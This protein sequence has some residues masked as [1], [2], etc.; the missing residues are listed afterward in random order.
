MP[1]SHAPKM[2]ANS[3]TSRRLAATAARQLDGPPP[4]S[5]AADVACAAAPDFAAPAPV[6]AGDAD[7]PSSGAAATMLAAPAPVVDAD[8]DVASAAG[9]GA[10]CVATAEVAVTACGTG[11]GPAAPTVAIAIGAAGDFACAVAMVA[12]VVPA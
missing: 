9:D 4:P 11:V 1:G 6:V 3:G 5:D 8:E 2:P 12:V 7:V 10:C